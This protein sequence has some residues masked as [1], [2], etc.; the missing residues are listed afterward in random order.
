MRAFYFTSRTLYTYFI[1][2]FH[3]FTSVRTA[4]YLPVSDRRSK[5]IYQTP[6]R[7][8][9]P[10][11]SFPIPRRLCTLEN[12]SRATIA[13]APIS[14]TYNTYNLFSYETEAPTRLH[15]LYGRYRSRKNFETCHVRRCEIWVN[16]KQQKELSEARDST[17]WYCYGGVLRYGKNMY[18]YPCS[19]LLQAKYRA[20]NCGHVGN[21]GLDFSTEPQ[22]AKSWND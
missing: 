22:L 7:R 5:Q 11:P 1:L 21:R 17:V 18:R 4:T 2:P 16:W 10:S 19:V 20:I 14:Y 9:S 8:F 6:Q 12:I 15:P 13:A 3:S